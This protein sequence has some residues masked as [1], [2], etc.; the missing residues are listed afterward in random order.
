MRIFITGGTGLIGRHLC[1]LL[2]GRGDEVL[3]LT[4]DPGA[5]RARMPEAVELIGGDPG[6]P[7]AWQ[8]RLAAC[9]AVINLAGES[10]GDGR[11]TRGRKQRLRRSRLGTTENVVKAMAAADRPQTLISASAVGYYGDRGDEALGEAAAPGSGFLSRLSVEWEHTATQAEREDTRVVLLRIGVVLAADG[12]ALPRM[13]TPFR[14]GAGGPLGSGRQYFPWI[15]L[16][17]LLQIILFALDEPGLSGP[18]N[19][20]VPDPPRQRDFARSLGRVLGKP[21]VLPAPAFALRLLLGEQAVL[22]LAGQRAVPNALKAHGYK[23]RFPEMEGALQD[24]L[25]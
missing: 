16:H 17:D 13:V 25:G 9:D 7:G 18:V 19:A 8:D 24:L 14:L 15:H 21:A 5:A 2:V 12:G 23:F 1:G 6:L 3:C 11:W 4:R 22:L 20:V 10:V